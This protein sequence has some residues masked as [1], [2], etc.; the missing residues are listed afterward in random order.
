MWLVLAP[1][2]V[3]AIVISTRYRPEFPTEPITQQEKP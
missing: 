1:I 2:I 3:L